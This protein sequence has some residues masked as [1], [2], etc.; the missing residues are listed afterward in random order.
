[1]CES[2]ERRMVCWMEAVIV[3]GIQGSGKSHFYRE[4]FFNSHLRISMDLLKTRARERR[5]L[6]LCLQTQ[7]PFVVDNTNATV[8]NRASYIGVARGRGFRVVGYFFEP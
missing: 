1:M 6:E 5:L 3:I 7:Q 4:R 8:A 2:C